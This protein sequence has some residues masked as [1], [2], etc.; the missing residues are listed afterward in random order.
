MIQKAIS[1]ASSL[2]ILPDEEVLTDDEIEEY[3]ENLKS[4][5]PSFVIILLKNNLK[6][7]RITKRQLDRIVERI[8]E[9]LSKSKTSR[10]EIEEMNKKLQSLEQ[11]L[12][13]I[14]KLTTVVA[15]SKISEE[16]EKSEIEEKKEEKEEEIKVEEVKEEKPIEEQEIKIEEEE[17][18]PE[19]IE[20]EE[21]EEIKVEEEKEEIPKE[22]PDV[23]GIEEVEEMLGEEQGYRLNDIPEDPISTALAFKWLQFLVSK[24]GTSNLPDVLDYYNKIG[25]ISNKVV[26]KLLRYSKNMRFFGGEE[27]NVKVNDKLTPSDHIMS[28]LYI[29]KLAG[30]P[31]DPDMLEMLE[32]EIRR[33][34]KWAE[35][36]RS[37]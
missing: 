16:I 26:L 23:E 31:L 7:R 21:E 3:L 10:D 5:L 33:F 29:E 14:M 30:R 19:E 9:V 12:D 25:W 35:E 4:K 6:G 28:F 32:I 37:I 24:V 27:E 18:E 34:K 13:T 20:L 2:E 22:I 1:E 17:I 8:S 15:S 11:K 36:L